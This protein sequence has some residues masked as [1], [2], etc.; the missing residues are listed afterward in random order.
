MTGLGPA[1]FF[2]IAMLGLA[3]ATSRGPAAGDLPHQ[4]CDNDYARQCFTVTPDECVALARSAVD[5]CTTK[6]EPE[7][8]IRQCA[9]VRLTLALL[10]KAIHSEK[11]FGHER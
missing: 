7:R 8:D 3:C 4:L 9:S 6:A 11:C 10:P 5:T 1:G 2:G